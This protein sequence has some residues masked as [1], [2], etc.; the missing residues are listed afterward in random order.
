MPSRLDFFHSLL[1]VLK[2]H[3]FKFMFAAVAGIVIYFWAIHGRWTIMIYPD[4]S[5]P[6]QI[7]YY[8]EYMF[9]DDCR[10][11]ALTLLA[12]QYPHGSYLCGFK[13]K[14]IHPFGKEIACER[15][16]Q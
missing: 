13:C 15:T 9:I 11:A 3:L 6:K 1:V 14:S 2:D 5:K 12:Q 4:P 7:E 8:G 16:E 10:E